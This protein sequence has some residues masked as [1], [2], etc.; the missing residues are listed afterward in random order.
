[1]QGVTHFGPLFKKP[2]DDLHFSI[3]GI[4][5]REAME[6]N[7]PHSHTITLGNQMIIWSH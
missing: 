4:D 6:E 1:M 3:S 7:M 2:K 5:R